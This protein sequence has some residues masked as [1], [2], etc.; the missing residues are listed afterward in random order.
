[1]PAA[2]FLLVTA[3]GK[4]LRIRLTEFAVDLPHERQPS[5][6]FLQFNFNQLPSYSV[7]GN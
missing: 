2:R 6:T 3:A 7:S 5:P 4:T 1:M